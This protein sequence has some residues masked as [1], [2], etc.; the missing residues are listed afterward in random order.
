MKRKEIVSALD[1]AKGRTQKQRYGNALK[2]KKLNRKHISDLTSRRKL[3][4]ISRAVPT[5]L[6]QEFQR[7]G[8]RSWRKSQ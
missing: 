3:I 2:E 6:R 1:F 8:S 5:M 4:G 7:S